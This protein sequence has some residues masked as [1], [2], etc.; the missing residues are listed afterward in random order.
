[1]IKLDFK[2][3]YEKVKCIHKYTYVAILRIRI[4]LQILRALCWIVLHQLD[5]N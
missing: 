4:Y 1:M 2:L 5:T 3:I